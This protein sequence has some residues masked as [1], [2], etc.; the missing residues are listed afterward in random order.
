M[1][2]FDNGQYFLRLWS[3]DQRGMP[4]DTT[5]FPFEVAIQRQLIGRPIKIAKSN[6]SNGFISLNLPKIKD[7][8]KYMIRLT[9]DTQG[10]YGI[11]HLI[12][13]ENTAIQ[14]PQPGVEADFY[15]FWIYA[16]Q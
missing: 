9:T 12:N 1:N 3:V 10:Q 16:Y 13:P 6:F 2:V 11:W 15:Y 8:L 4:S 14:V 5:L 7:P